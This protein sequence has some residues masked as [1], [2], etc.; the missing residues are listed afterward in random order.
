[1]TTQPPGDERR[2]ERATRIAWIGTGILGAV[3][4]ALGVYSAIASAT[5]SSSMAAPDGFM[6]VVGVL[7]GGLTIAGAVRLRRHDPGGIRFASIILRVILVVAAGNV[8]CSFTGGIGQNWGHLLWAV[9][10]TV[11]TA[12][13]LAAMEQLKASLGRPPQ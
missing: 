2:I 8:V 6:A 1:M 4:L 5:T 3:V 13:L 9:I 7:L 10:A 11:V 12:T